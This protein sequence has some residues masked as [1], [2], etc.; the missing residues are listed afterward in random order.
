MNK[1][2]EP[3]RD[4]PSPEPPRLPYPHGHSTDG[5]APLRTDE[6]LTPDVDGLPPRA[7]VSGA[8]SGMS[9]R[10]SFPTVAGYELL[11]ELGRGTMGVVYKARQT[12]L[13]RLVA[14]KMIVAGGHATEEQRARFENEARAV[15]ALQ[16]P[17]IVQIH[18]LGTSD[19]LPFLSL[20]FVDGM[21]LDA[22]IDGMPQ[23]PQ[24]A[25][26]LIEVLARAIQVAHAHG[27]IHR[28]L[29]PANVLVAGD[30][31][32]KITDFGLAK[33]LESTSSQT[34]S[35]SQIGTPS[36]M[37]PEQA[38]SESYGH[39]VDV[40]ALGAILYEML[41][42]RPPFLGA[43]P[44]E[45]TMLVVN[46]EPVRPSLLVSQVPADVE[47]ICLK[48]LQKDPDRRY[49]DAAALAED[50]RRFLAG[51]PILSRPIS[52]AERL[53]RWCRR[54]PRTSALAAAVVGLLALVAVGSTAAAI[55]IAKAR[56][57]A[58]EANLVAD[59]AK[60]AAI[61]N[62]LLADKRT[63]L[64]LA[65]Y[66]TLVE[67]VRSLEETPGTTT[68]KRKLLEES[69]NGV[70]SLAG[71][72]GDSSSTETTALATHMLLGN[73]YSS[74]G[75]TTEA[76]D[77]YLTAHTIA[78]NRA[79][80]MPHNDAAQGNLAAVLSMLGTM[81]HE[82]EQDMVAC[83]DCY[84]QSLDIWRKLQAGPPG[85]EG[86]V[87]PE[88]I[89]ANLAEGATNLGVM[90]L[91]Q[92]LVKE[93]TLLIQEGIDSRQKLLDRFPE[94]VALRSA[95]AVSYQ[96]MGE[97]CY[98]TGELQEAIRYYGLSLST[99]EDLHAANRDDAATQIALAEVLG[100]FGD[101]HLRMGEIGNARSLFERSLAL[102][103]DVL[104]LDGNDVDQARSVAYD[105]HRLGTVESMAGDEEESARRFD[106]ARRMREEI[107]AI[108]PKNSERQI[109]L[110]LTRS[111]CGDVEGALS[112]AASIRD[113][114]QASTTD[115]LLALAR[116]HAQCSV[117]LRPTDPAAADIQVNSAVEAVRDAVAAG[118]RDRVT[119]TIDPDM[120]P[121]QSLSAYR[122]IVA[123]MA[124]P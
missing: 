113:S 76:L 79:R 45:T 78:W 11:S 43:S 103:R 94:E 122:E 1:A 3:G 35:G 109:E 65:S 90:L 44:Y 104:A 77:Q 88:T 46:E 31:T 47:T 38:M 67:A 56:N 74:L 50:C 37:A 71:N 116:C 17:N 28:D 107:V 91:N 117:K 101:L 66:Q 115:L 6:A 100:N 95:Q 123:G 20:E 73:L 70:N 106:E 18:E 59:A 21:P 93:S 32:P 75:K 118:Y 114:V 51:E 19:G 102:H 12:A 60:I 55:R 110:M 120:L 87:E 27:I 82:L 58:V 41:V 25:V 72:M 121:L 111:R 49:A 16:H 97:A 48:C 98:L 81:R 5:S 53:W 68:L 83:I 69:L 105:L 23:P 96:A 112:I 63:N 86:P 14:L 24:A 22:R 124:A 33:D 26:A 99:N 85:T 13:Q 52:P 92:G 34:R 57:D 39:L 64:A 7:L 61:D 80:H 119:L 29:K 62:A 9:S 40:Y 108:D 8:W 2:F 15:A 54:N 4:R 36:Y 89:E 84:R 30:G 42:G 10:S